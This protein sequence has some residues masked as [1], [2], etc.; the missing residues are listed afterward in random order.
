MLAYQ[1]I[2]LRILGIRKQSKEAIRCSEA[3]RPQAMTIRQSLYRNF[4]LIL[5]IAVILLMVNFF[6]MWREQ[7]AADATQHSMEMAQACEQVRNQMMENRLQL[8]NY[9]LGDNSAYGSMNQGLARLRDLINVARAKSTTE[10][11]I[12]KN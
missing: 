9:L 4:S 7:S 10:V 6:A 2:M 3:W 8:R 12:S 1:V 5:G 11:K